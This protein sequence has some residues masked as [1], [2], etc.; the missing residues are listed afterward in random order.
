M[1]RTVRDIHADYRLYAM[2]RNGSVV[3]EV[4]TLPNG[5]CIVSWPTSTIVYDSEDIARQVH[6]QHMGERGQAT[7]FEL[8]HSEDVRARAS[9]DCVQDESENAPFASVGGLDMRG[10][11]QLP[12]Y[13]AVKDGADYIGGYVAQAYRLYGPDWQT[14]SFGWRP[15][16]TVN[17]EAKKTDD[18]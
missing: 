12:R 10:S 8:Q 13:V 9:V 17:V 14:C 6:I 3:A 11:M 18:D 4:I 5:K 1:V 2:V 15:A 16:M 7:S